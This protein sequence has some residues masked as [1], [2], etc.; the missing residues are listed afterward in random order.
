MKRQRTICIAHLF[1]PEIKAS[2]YVHSGILRY[3][4]NHCDLLIRSILPGSYLLTATPDYS[5]VRQKLR[6]LNPDGV[7]SPAS[8]LAPAPGEPS[9]P[10]TLHS[11]CVNEYAD[12]TP[13][14]NPRR[15]TGYLDDQAIVHA[16]VDLALRRQHRH[17]AY[18]D[19]L[20]PV[21]RRRSD[22]R[23]R[24]YEQELSLSGYELHR[25]RQEASASFDE[26]LQELG[27]WLKTLPKP[28]M[29]FAYAD[30]RARDV[31]DAC[32]LVR[33]A[34]PD[35]IN[36]IGIDNDAEICEMVEPTLTSIQPDF[37]LGG[38]LLAQALH[39]R[40]LSNRVP[41]RGMTLTYG[42]KSVIERGTTQDLRGGGRLVIRA[43]ALIRNSLADSMLRAP[44]IAAALNVSRQLLDLRF[45]EIVGRTV[46]DEIERLRIEKA[47]E[48]LRTNARLTIAEVMSACG[49]V[50]ANSFRSAFKAW[51]QNAPAEFRRL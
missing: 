50:N 16:A 44:R 29:V 9:L 48:L 40:I 41:K 47:C 3:A 1:H 10:E 22:M 6:D 12:R 11:A 18:V 15:I 28:C 23:A 31:I 42:V 34:I 35:Q 5:D 26:N 49:Y 17:F 27:I 45:R 32:H 46:R 4:R 24:L 51:T 2:R 14:S 25:L 38:Y 21:E 19:S 8:W 13:S 20:I 36:V 43:Q 30:E 37:E 7:V 33:L 39:R